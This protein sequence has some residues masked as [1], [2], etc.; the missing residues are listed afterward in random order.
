MA[1]DLPLASPRSTRYEAGKARLNGLERV[2]RQAKELLLYMKRVS[3]P[4]Y[5]LAPRV[6]RLVLAS[7]ASW[8]SLLTTDTSM[9]GWS[10][11]L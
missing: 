5:W 1:R 3:E 8:P 6:T 2:T 10:S 9:I 11:I 7:L 4:L